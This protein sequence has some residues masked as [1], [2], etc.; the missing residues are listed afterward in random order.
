MARTGPIHWFGVLLILAASICLLVTTISAPVVNSIS[1]LRVDTHNGSSVTFGTFGYCVINSQQGGDYC[2]GRSIG[3][4]PAQE[5]GNVEGT[6][7]SEAGADTANGLT[8]VMVLHPI[9]CG[10]AFIAFLVSLGAGVIGSLIG[11]VITFIAWIITLVVLITDLVG[12][13]IVR[14]DVNGDG[15]NSRAYYGSGLWTLVAAF[16]L[17]FL[18]MFILLFTCFSARR[19]KKR[20]RQ[21]AAEPKNDYG[22]QVGGRRRWY[23]FRRSGY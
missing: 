15:Q 5:M 13:A 16:V 22:T 19:Q 9:A 6:G 2:S 7:F 8:N 1:I 18:G 12:F 23:N 21:A 11:A 17:L 3:Y 4:R 14:N 20:E 10:V